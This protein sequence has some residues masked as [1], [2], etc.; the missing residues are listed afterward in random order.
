MVKDI[1]N[2]VTDQAHTEAFGSPALWGRGVPQEESFNKHGHVAT[3]SCA[4][5][6]PSSD[7]HRD[8]HVVVFSQASDINVQDVVKVVSNTREAPR[9]S[10]FSKS[11][12]LLLS[13]TPVPQP[14]SA[15]TGVAPHLRGME[16][17][18][19]SGMAEGVGCMTRKRREL[20]E[21]MGSGAGGNSRTQ[22]NRR[23][24]NGQLV[25]PPPEVRAPA[26]PLRNNPLIRKRLVPVVN[27]VEHGC[28]G[29]ACNADVKESPRQDENVHGDSATFSAFPANGVSAMADC[30]SRVAE[31]AEVQTVTGD[32]AESGVSLAV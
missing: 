29:N 19:T 8:W 17:E 2:F 31:E 25:G 26:A 15:A 24:G 7:R 6:V 11:T 21:G 22:P 32:V 13:R 5:A 16:G 30:V 4:T 10:R 9:R 23:D 20:D 27:A 28:Y 12:R 1:F 3:Q 18:K 14:T